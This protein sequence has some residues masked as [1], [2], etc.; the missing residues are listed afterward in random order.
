MNAL[1]MSKRNWMVSMWYDIDSNPI[2]LKKYIIL[3]FIKN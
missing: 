3:K 2:D 1:I